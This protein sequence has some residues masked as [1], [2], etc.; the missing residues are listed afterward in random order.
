MYSHYEF[1]YSLI[2]LSNIH[3]FIITWTD[4]SKNLNCIVKHVCDLQYNL[5]GWVKGGMEMFSFSLAEGFRCGS[6]MIRI[7]WMGKRFLEFLLCI[8][9][10][11]YKQISVGIYK[12]NVFLNIFFVLRKATMKYWVSP[13]RRGSI[14]YPQPLSTFLLQPIYILYPQPLSTFLLQ[15][16]YIYLK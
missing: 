10:T 14:L 1:N 7:R 9:E 2:H 4:K 13:M 8:Y 15:P 3:L 5:F 6:G 11:K 12:Y 16:I